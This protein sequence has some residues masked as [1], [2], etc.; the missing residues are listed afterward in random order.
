MKLNDIVEHAKGR[1]A[2]IYNR[3]PKNMIEPHKPQAPTG[4]VSEAEVTLKPL[5]GAQEVDVDGKAVGTA[6]TPQ[7]ATAISDLAKKGEFTPAT[8]DN[9]QPAAMEDEVGTPY[10]VKL[11]GNGPV[12]KSGNGF[13]PI[14]ASKI[15]DT[16]TPEIEAKAHSQGFRK[17]TLSVNGAMIPALEGGGKVIVGKTSYGT[18]V[19]SQNEEHNHHGVDASGDVGGD[20]TDSFLDQIKLQPEDD[21]GHGISE[22]SR[23]RHLA[24]LKEA[25]APSTLAAPAPAP[26]TT[27]IVPAADVDPAETAL[28]SAQVDPELMQQVEANTVRDA[29]GDVDLSATFQKIADQ[30]PAEPQIRAEWAEAFKQFDEKFSHIEQDPEF[31]KMTPEEQVKCKQ[32]VQEVRAL[33]QKF[34]EF[35]VQM[36]N[37]VKSGARQ[38][39]TA[40]AAPGAQNPLQGV[41]TLVPQQ[42]S[43]DLTAML[44]IAGLR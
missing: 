30:I 31:M 26:T 11:T 8:S 3:K 38:V 42:E 44:R 35:A 29:E 32:D 43:A 12:V 36:S 10:F 15:W 28:K 37:T 13:T 2:K 21:I 41:K 14:V 40:M 1:R 34:M 7:A 19:N 4:P 39:R 5:A 24:G 23:I 17:I 22:M 9:Q 6:T 16:M 18:I 33:F 20:A 27:A 25:D